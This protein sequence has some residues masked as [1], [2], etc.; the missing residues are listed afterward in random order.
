MKTLKQ[1]RGPF[2]HQGQS[3]KLRPALQ[4]K[5]GN[6][7][8]TTTHRLL[9]NGCYTTLVYSTSYLGSLKVRNMRSVETNTTTNPPPPSAPILSP[10]AT[11]ILWWCRFGIKSQSPPRKE[12]IKTSAAPRSESHSCTVLDKENDFLFCFAKMFLKG[13]LGVVGGCAVHSKL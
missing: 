7:T 13:L 4:L 11:G 12:A 1:Q 8:G 6:N 3:Y 9:W 5:G 10:N 2:Y